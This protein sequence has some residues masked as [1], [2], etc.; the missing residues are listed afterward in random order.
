MVLSIGIIRN[1]PY[2]GM[3]NVMRNTFKIQKCNDHVLFCAFIKFHINK[4]KK[5]IYNKKKHDTKV[6]WIINKIKRK[7]NNQLII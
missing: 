6:I 1:K 5:N 3:K 2:K 4:F 7:A